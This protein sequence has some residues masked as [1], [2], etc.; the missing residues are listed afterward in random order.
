MQQRTP[1]LHA[2]SQKV[3]AK[4]K[5]KERENEI[6]F[7]DEHNESRAGYSSVAR[8]RLAGAHC[9]YEESE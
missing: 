7:D 9:I 1:N 5:S 2:K 3:S 8:E 4:V 6:H